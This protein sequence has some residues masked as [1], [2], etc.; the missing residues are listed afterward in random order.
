MLTKR[1]LFWFQFWLR[2]VMIIYIGLLCGV[3]LFGVGSV[4]MGRDTVFSGSAIVF[5]FFLVVVVPGLSARWANALRALRVLPTTSW[6]LSLF[7][8][9]IPVVGVISTTVPLVIFYDLLHKPDKWPLILTAV[10]FSLGFSVILCNAVIWYGKRAL[11]LGI[12]AAPI[13]LMLFGAELFAVVPILGVVMVP[14]LRYQIKYSNDV[15]RGRG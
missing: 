13:S 3:G 10:L 2:Q 12:I 6:R 15:Y 14:V 11:W 9:S 1:I 4:A 7:L 5:L 8:L